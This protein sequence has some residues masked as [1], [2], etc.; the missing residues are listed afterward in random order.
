MVQLYVQK[1]D[2]INT[3]M[4]PP[5]SAILNG[6]GIGMRLAS[7]NNRDGPHGTEIKY[8]YSQITI[9][10]LLKYI[11]NKHQST[12]VTT[13]TDGRVAGVVGGGQNYNITGK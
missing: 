9:L 5:I 12:S 10:R 7:E 2:K 3:E 4:Y 13:V 1:F 8:D 6:R 11:Y